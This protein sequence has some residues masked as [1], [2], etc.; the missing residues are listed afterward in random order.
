[1]HQQ[2]ASAH[3]PRSDDFGN[4][5]MMLID[6]VEKLSAA[7]EPDAI[8]RIVVDAARR[9]AGADGASFVLR[10]GDLCHYVDEDAVAPLWKGGRFPASACI[11]GWCMSNRETAVIMDIDQD[12]RIPHDMHRTTFVRSLVSVPVGG[13]DPIA[14]IGV[15][16]DREQAP[17]AAAVVVLEALARSTATALA[18]ATRHQTLTKRV[19]ELAALYRLTD[20]LYRAESLAD[21][22][23]AALDA[24]FSAFSCNRASILLFDE[25]GVMRFVA[26][27]GLSEHYR[28]ALEG[29]SPW[30]PGD[31]DPEA[32]FVADIDIT[33]EPEPVKAV[34]RGEGIRAL[35]FI[36]LVSKGTV[37][38]KFMIYYESSHLFADH[39]VDLAV[40]IARQLGFSIERLYAEKA[41]GIAAQELRRSEDL[42]RLTTR[43]GK[44]GLWEWDIELN[45]VSWTDSLYSIH[46]VEKETFDATVEGFAALV[47]PEDRARVSEAIEQTLQEDTPYDLEFRAVRPDGQVI[48]LF[49][50]AIVLRD[51]MKPVRMVG[52]TFDI[53]DHKHAEERFRLAVEAAPSGMVLADGEGRI[54]LVNA[55]AEKL[56]G[57]GR[58]ELVGQEIELLVPRRFR[59]THPGFRETYA[60]QPSARPMGAGRDLFAL[61]KDGTEVPVEIGLSPIRTDEGL[62][63][64]SAI[65]DISERKRAES[66]RELLLAELNHRVKNT[67]AVVQGIAHQ[68]FKRTDASPEARRA[69]E[70]RLAALAAAH[71]L[72]T[73]ANWE[74]A[75]LEHLTAEALQVR[76]VNEQRLS[77]AG[78]RV[79]LQPKQA[80]AVAMALHELCT[81]AIKYGALSNESGSVAFE[82]RRSDG[83]AP[84]LTMVWREQGGPAVSPPAR[85]GFGSRM[86]ERALA[87]DLRG[88]VTMEFRPE[89]FVCTIDAPLPQ[90]RAP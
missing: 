80:L 22:Y 82:W 35:A 65:V 39:E 6:A 33:N 79:H 68:T 69:F 26:W 10:D 76:A 45:R 90:E 64:L 73:R 31:R 77:F 32:I 50:S 59:S 85:R 3:S 24:I 53:T 34:I 44:I 17:D 41:H 1:M 60:D 47:H 8:A 83:P 27:R 2:T 11:A 58:D 18:S 16:W 62:I 48:W 88:E 71:N 36:P 13:E 23:Y 9:L 56:F 70:G 61:Q 4:A 19:D 40:T 86:I 54:V 51:G 38:G 74:Q 12:E 21:T 89:G 78:P 29:H 67:L 57:Y 28:A 63:V 15:Y 46:Q 37:V 49:T 5:W 72:L 75:S 52:A 7:H 66:Q 81:N 14:A 42:L 55:H 20:K 87:Q 30:K 43:T 25:A 84:R